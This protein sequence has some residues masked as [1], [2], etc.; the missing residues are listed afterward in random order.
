MFSLFLLI[1][2]N[3]IAP[4]Y[5]DLWMMLCS[6]FI[7]FMNNINIIFWLVKLSFSLLSYAIFVYAVI[8]PYLDILNVYAIESNSDVPNE[9]KRATPL[10]YVL[11]FGFIAGLLVLQLLTNTSADAGVIIDVATKQV[12]SVLP[13]IESAKDSN[14]TAV[15][16]S[17]QEANQTPVNNPQ[18]LN[19]VP[20]DNPQE[21]QSPSSPCSQASQWETTSESS[22]VNENVNE[23]PVQVNESV[24]EQPT[25]QTQVQVNPQLEILNRIDVFKA[26][27]DPKLR[28]EL[29]MQLYKSVGINT[30]IYDQVRFDKVPIQTRVDHQ[31]ILCKAA[32]IDTG[33]MYR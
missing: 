11:F 32:G 29:L 14:Q 6:L 20:V 9:E 16:D 33:Y 15:N 8:Y 23:Q 1:I 31:S 7:F 22:Q 24:V 3:W 30:E 27:E 5:N 19:Q 12:D 17:L 28:H 2:V 21:V 25:M 10:G 26:C 18:E 13:N 4:F